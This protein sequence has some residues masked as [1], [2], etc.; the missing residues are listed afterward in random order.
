MIDIHTHTVYSDGADTPEE[1][2]R[3]AAQA[4]LTHLS[5][6][7]HNSV[8]AYRDP[9][10]DHWRDLFPGTLIRGVEITCMY[11]G[12][13]VEVLGYGY[14]LDKLEALLPQLVLP[15]REKQLREAELIAAAFGRAGVVYDKANI[16]FDPDRGSS[17]KAFL[18]E[19]ITL[20]L[21]PFPIQDLMSILALLKKRWTDFSPIRGWPVMGQ[22]LNLFFTHIKL[23]AV[24]K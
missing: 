18:Q 4:G 24:L 7:D 8:S 2:L 5:I 19:P 11:E 17:R 15:F 6:T 10:M 16:T 20:Y 21:I 3:H 22:R 23:R 9:V 1:L 12:E 14:A 13:I